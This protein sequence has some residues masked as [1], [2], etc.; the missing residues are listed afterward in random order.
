MNTKKHQTLCFLSHTLPDELALKL[1]STLILKQSDY[2][3]RMI[4]THRSRKERA[5]NKIKLRLISIG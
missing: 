5:P 3:R 2:K 1:K 4:R